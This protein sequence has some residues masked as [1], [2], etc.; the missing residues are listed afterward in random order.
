MEAPADPPRRPAPRRRTSGP[1]RRPRPRRRPWSASPTAGTACTW[2]PRDR[3]RAAARDV[4]RR[5]SRLPAATRAGLAH[6][7]P[8]LLEVRL[9]PL[10]QLRVLALL[11][12]PR[13]GAAGELQG[14]RLGEQHALGL[15][16]A[17]RRARLR[18]GAGRHEALEPLTA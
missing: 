5:R 14:R 11:L 1:R 4:R 17:A 2:R 9:R 16:A 8:P 6:L 12:A 18:G 13:A 10:T 7:P 3:P 15:L